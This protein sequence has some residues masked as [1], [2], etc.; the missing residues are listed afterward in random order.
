M[1]HEKYVKASCTS[2]NRYNTQKEAEF[3]VFTEIK[4][5]RASYL[6]A[7]ECEICSGFHLT[8]KELPQEKPIVTAS[9]PNLTY[10]AFS[11]LL[12]K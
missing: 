6:R 12:T 2:K 11:I 1:A 10:K 5:K 7:Y 4:S 3:K 8:H 9:L